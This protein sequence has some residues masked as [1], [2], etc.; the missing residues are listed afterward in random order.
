MSL[1]YEC[2]FGEIPEIFKSEFAELYKTPYCTI[3][4]VKLF[5]GESLL[6]CFSI[7]D[8][9]RL[10]HLILFT[11]DK[12][13]II[14]ILNRVVEI[15]AQYLILFSNFI[16]KSKLKIDKIQVNHITNQIL[17]KQIAHFICK[18]FDEDYIIKL[19]STSS[20]Y[21][22]NLS[23]NQRSHTKRSISKI[24]RT[25]GSYSFN[26]FEK[27]EITESIINKIFEM[28]YSRMRQKNIEWGYDSSYIENIK[29]FLQ[30]FGLV[31]TFEINGEVVAGVIL[32]SIKNGFFM[33]AISNDPKYNQFSVGHTCLY[34]TIQECILRNGK[35]FHLL[36]GNSPY[37]QRF[38]AERLQLYSVIV[39][40]TNFLKLKH[41]LLPNLSFKYIFKLIKRRIK[42]TYQKVIDCLR[43][44]RLRENKIV[45]LND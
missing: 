3:E 24:E 21:F 1:K 32:Y 33:E 30:D 14:T 28:N 45:N 44:L 43:K 13:E 34:L 41:K 12:N 27:K 2:Y 16:F 19:P 23:F 35:E 20:E 22:S 6:N 8:E 29:K 36:W 18:P 7:H 9:E 38:L 31:S 10:I 4:Y 15:D 17:D 5:C 39:F 40:R 25:F 42:N 26:L 11:I 37:K